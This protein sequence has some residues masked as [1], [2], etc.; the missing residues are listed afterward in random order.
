MMNENAN[1][2]G[3][4]EDAKDN[5]MYAKIHNAIF[6]QF[7]GVIVKTRE[8]ATSHSR[9]FALMPILCV[10]HFHCTCQHIAYSCP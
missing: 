7:F 2:V 3:Y 1:S 5:P 8:D 10:E 4:G 9:L 6:L